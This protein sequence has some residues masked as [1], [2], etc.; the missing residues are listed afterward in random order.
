MVG[1]EALS[2][3]NDRVVLLLSPQKAACILKPE[4]PLDLHPTNYTLSLSLSDANRHM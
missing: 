3:G 4:L 2:R 1:Q